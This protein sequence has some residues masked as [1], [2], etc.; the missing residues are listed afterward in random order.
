MTSFAEAPPGDKKSGE[1]IFKTKC[2]QCHTV[3][4]GAG[5]KQEFVNVVDIIKDS[6]PDISRDSGMGSRHLVGLRDGVPSYHPMCWNR[7]IGR[8]ISIPASQSG[9]LETFLIPSIG[10]GRDGGAMRKSEQSY[11]MKFKTLDIIWD[12]GAMRKPEQSY[13]MKF[14]TLDIICDLYI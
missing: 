7:A 10:M 1:K 14:K 9:R 8:P 12:G 11:P 5:H 6:G 13:P 4:K 3:E 2:A